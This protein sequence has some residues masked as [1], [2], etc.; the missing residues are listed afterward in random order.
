MR[1]GQESTYGAY[2]S[3]ILSSHAHIIADSDKIAWAIA[4]IVQS[5]HDEA[6]RVRPRRV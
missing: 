5:L 6:L 2:R 4:P 3:E 1:Q